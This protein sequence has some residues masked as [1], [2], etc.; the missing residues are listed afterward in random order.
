MLAA[1]NIIDLLASA[2]TG[3]LNV[4]GASQ[5]VSDIIAARIAAG[6][7]TWTDE[8]RASITADLE[9]AKAK[10]D[11]QIKAAGG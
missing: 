1:L 5:K 11:A 2:I 9:A 3:L 7:T 4:L 6:R 8:E 10:A